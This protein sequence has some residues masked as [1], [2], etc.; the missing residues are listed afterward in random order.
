VTTIRIV[1]DYRRVPSQFRAAVAAIGNFDGVHRG[2]RALIGRSAEIAAAADAPMGLVTFEPHPRRVFAP[3][4]PPFRLTPFRNKARILAGLGVEVLFALRFNAALHRK[5]ADE[6]VADVLVAGL[7]L[8]HVVIGYDFVFGRGRAGNAELMQRL[9]EVHDFQVTVIGPVMHDD[10]VCSSTII[11]VDL[12]GGRARRAAELLGHWWEIEGRVRGG[13][14]RGRTIGFPTAN[15]H[16]SPGAFRPALG[17]YA[18]HVGIDGPNGT[19]W[20]T[21]AAN[22]GRRPTVDGQGIVL[23][24]HVFDFSGDLY[25]RQ[26]RVAFVEHLRPERR[27]DGL[28]ALKAQIG[29]DC[30]QARAVLARPENALTA[31]PTPCAAQR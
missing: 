2:H 25:A 14:R 24:V 15:L 3:D 21:G 23:E 27:F 8:G 28:E 13:D 10:D 26:V 16:L 9:G 29:R 31:Y 22:L 5:T 12:E 17:V 4:S 19:T 30:E 1:R 7:G 11:R 6:F 18:V 20:H